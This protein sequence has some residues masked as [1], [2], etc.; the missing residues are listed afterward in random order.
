MGVKLIPDTIDRLTSLTPEQRTL[1]V[2]LLDEVMEG[3]AKSVVDK[4]GERAQKE[5][6]ARYE[7]LTGEQVNDVDERELED[8]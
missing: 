7:D 8:L 5:R 2:E 3:V 4:F 1:I 6:A